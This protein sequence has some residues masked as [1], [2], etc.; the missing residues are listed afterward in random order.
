MPDAFDL[1]SLA[2]IKRT[3]VKLIVTK[4]RENT[5]VRAH[6]VCNWAALFFST[7]H[8]I[9]KIAVDLF[10]C[11]LV[12][13]FF[14]FAS[15]LLFI[16]TTVDV[17][18]WISNFSLIVQNKWFAVMNWCTSNDKIENGHCVAHGSRFPWS[19]LKKKKTAEI[20]D[21]P[22]VMKICGR[23]IFIPD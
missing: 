13:C 19:G 14:F 4:W 1:R 9:L 3:I 17:A 16:A 15:L 22:A 8:S 11:S 18:L 12:I 20:A 23:S 21:R 5:T 2:G 7:H 10:I 6:T